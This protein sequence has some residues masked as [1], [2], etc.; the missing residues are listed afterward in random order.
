MPLPHPVPTRRGLSRCARALRRCL[1]LPALAAATAQAQTGTA[2]LT[3]YW[4]PGQVLA[5]QGDST[6]VPTETRGPGEATD[7]DI[8]ASRTRLRARVGSDGSP[9]EGAA[10][11]MLFGH[12]YTHVD[13]SGGGESVP[14]RL[15]RQ[16]MDVGFTLDE[17]TFYVGGDG[18]F[19]GA[20]TPALEVGFGHASTNPYEDDRGWYGLASVQAERVSANGNRLLLG[21]TY[22][23][24]RSTLPDLP[25]PLVLFRK[26]LSIDPQTGRPSAAEIGL[27]LGYPETRLIYK[28]DTRWTLSAG[29]SQLD[30]F[31]ALAS[32]RV[33]EHV[34]VLA[35][36]GGFY[37]QFHDADTKE[38]RRIFVVGQR[39]EVG[40]T[41]TPVQRLSFTLTG[42][43]GFGQQL[44]RG[45]DLRSTEEIQEFD[46]AAF[47]R[48]AARLSF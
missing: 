48:V 47:V 29:F 34:T 23:G 14:E 4:E 7:T 5:V 15:V 26:P 30:A 36:Y 16:E 31:T 3:S 38:R 2:L 28:P 35:G 12:E 20:W 25:L 40:A 43:W 13:F 39:L 8:W 10:G 21:L 24:N 22:D 46:D 11:G 32:Y 37:D 33:N 1:L 44:R 19:S 17:Q 6:R 27:T 42:G 45:Y 9:G 18:L 41:I